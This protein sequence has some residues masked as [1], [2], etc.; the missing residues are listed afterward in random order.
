[1]KSAIVLERD[2]D[3]FIVAS[4]PTLPACHSQGRTDEEAV[5]NV[6]EAIRGYV[7]SMRKHDEVR[8]CQLRI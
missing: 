4:C 2:E 8:Q 5:A 6:K 1:M 3:G 7:A